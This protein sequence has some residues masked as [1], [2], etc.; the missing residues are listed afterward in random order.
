MVHTPVNGYIWLRTK[1]QKVGFFYSAVYSGFRMDPFLTEMPCWI[2]AST[3][4]TKS[5]KSTTEIFEPNRLAKHQL[6]VLHFNCK[7]VGFRW[8]CSI[9]Q[10]YCKKASR[11]H[12]KRTAL[13]TQCKIRKYILKYTSLKMSRH[14]TQRHN[15]Q[16]NDT[17]C[18]SVMAVHG[19]ISLIMFISWMQMLKHGQY[20]MNHGLSCMITSINNESQSLTYV[21]ITFHE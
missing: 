18:W 19:K 6:S 3:A 17:V 16:W 14:D 13:C 9:H 20:W 4:Q 12:K 5:Q 11:Y 10:P 2:S 21:K 8:N 1:W 7:F 15:T